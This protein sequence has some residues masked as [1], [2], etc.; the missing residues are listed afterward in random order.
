MTVAGQQKKGTMHMLLSAYALLKAA[1]VRA[2]GEDLIV[3]QGCLEC[4]ERLPA[5]QRRAARRRRTM[6]M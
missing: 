2:Q 1:K 3:V 6:R 4:L 5:I